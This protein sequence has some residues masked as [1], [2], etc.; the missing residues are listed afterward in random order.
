MQEV[1]HRFGDVRE[2][3]EIKHARRDPGIAARPAGS[4]K[5]VPAFKGP[6]MEP[7]ASMRVGEVAGMH[8]ELP[9]CLVDQFTSAARLTV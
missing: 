6:A 3:E 9:R 4:G 7:Q 1:L 2:I 8:E 5:I